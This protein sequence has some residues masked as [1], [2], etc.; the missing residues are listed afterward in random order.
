METSRISVPAKSL[1]ELVVA[2][3]LENSGAKME[4]MGKTYREITQRSLVFDGTIN[5]SNVVKEQIGTS[6]P[7]DIIELSAMQ[8]SN[9][10]N[11]KIPKRAEIKWLRS[12]TR[13]VD[14]FNIAVLD[15]TKCSKEEY[16]SKIHT[17]FKSFIKS[18]FDR[19]HNPS[20]EI[21]AVSPQTSN[22][23]LFA[24]LPEIITKTDVDVL[25]NTPNLIR[26]K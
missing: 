22:R 21:P 18:F 3:Y 9:K 20:V 13:L 14:S 8:L 12:V 19:K 4:R 15:K 16:E 17:Y 5:A 6:F 24:D 7:S 11:G 2:P 10:Y 23:K 25:L 1:I 26:H